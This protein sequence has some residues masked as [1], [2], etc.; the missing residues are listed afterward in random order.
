MFIYDWKWIVGSCLDGAL[1][2]E[3]QPWIPSMIDQAR[4]L[5]DSLR[6]NFVGMTCDDVGES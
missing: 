3:E 1:L 6:S 5:F 4:L 2:M